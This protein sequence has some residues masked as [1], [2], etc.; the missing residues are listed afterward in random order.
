MVADSA[1]ITCKICKKFVASFDKV[2]ADWR[3]REGQSGRFVC[4]YC[5]NWRPLPTPVTLEGTRVG[6]R[7]TWALILRG[8]RSIRSLYM[9]DM[10][11][12]AT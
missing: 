1:K 3:E 8:E 7:R 5:S 10:A 12:M 2:R 9:Y 4:L 11:T 6:R